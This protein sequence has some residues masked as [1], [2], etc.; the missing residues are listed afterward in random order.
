MDLVKINTIRIDCLPQ[1]RISDLN[2]AN[3][4]KH[5]G[6]QRPGYIRLNSIIVKYSLSLCLNIYIRRNF[7]NVLHNF[8]YIVKTLK[9]IF[10]QFKITPVKS[11]TFRTVNIQ[12]SGYIPEPIK[13]Q[14][15]HSIDNH[16]IEI[17]GAE[18]NNTAL[19]RNGTIP[20]STGYIFVSVNKSNK[21]RLNYRGYF[22]IVATKPRTFVMVVELLERVL[23]QIKYESH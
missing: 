8:N 20:N 3:C 6:S 2:S 1:P 22:T 21:L 5:L 11:Y 18:G 9:R 7:L 23:Q 14:R 10:N 12:A 15:L 17:G 4:H 19:P 16:T 13:L